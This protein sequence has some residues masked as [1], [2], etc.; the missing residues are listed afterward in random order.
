MIT[1]TIEGASV[2]E[3]AKKVAELASF[4]GQG[5]KMD[6]PKSETK[7]EAPKAEP[8]AEPNPEPK[9]VEKETVKRSE[10]TQIKP[11]ET[12]VKVAQLVFEDP[13]PK[14]T[15]GPATQMD[16]VN[17]LQRVINS[18]AKNGLDEAKKLLMGFGYARM[19][20]VP[21]KIYGEVVAACDKHL[22]FKNVKA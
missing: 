12:E 1:I 9:K 22:E 14:K 10:P 4:M 19:K 11:A 17:A 7:T 20:E 21:E 13:V 5:S 18:D 16:L 6:M 8:K 3:V 2:S 15:E